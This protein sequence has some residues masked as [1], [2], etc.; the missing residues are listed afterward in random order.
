LK[1]WTTVA[2]ALTP[3]GQAISLIEHDGDY[4]IRIGAAELMSTR[5]HASEELLAELACDHIRAARSA[6]VLIGG[7]GFGF[8][9]KAALSLLGPD[10]KVTVA[11]LLAAVVAWNAN[12][13]LPLAA[14]AMADARVTVLQRDVASLIA[15]SRANFDAII[16]DVDNG[17]QALTSAGNA[18]LYDLA[19]LRSIRV[20][21]RPGG[22]VAFWSAAPAPAFAALLARAGFE[23]EERRARARPNAGRWHTLFLGRL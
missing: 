4:S 10:A 8:T 18:R 19:G 12:S 5:Q 6:S 9:L 2:S 13:A 3:D 15:E 7:L 23:V 1:K 16:L 22:C 17:P 14:S 20:A 11:E 21:L